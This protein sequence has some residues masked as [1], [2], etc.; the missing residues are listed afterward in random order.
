M[1]SQRA[2]ALT[3][4]KLCDL[5]GPDS[6]DNFEVEQYT[7]KRCCPCLVTRAPGHFGLK[8]AKIADYA[9]GTVFQ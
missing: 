3:D 7:E 6:I 2:Q 1:D 5:T 4:C 8:I 9:G